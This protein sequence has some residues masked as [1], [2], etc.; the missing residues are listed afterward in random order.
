MHAVDPPEEPPETL[1]GSWGFFVMPKAEFSV[2]E[3]IANSSKFVFPI[4]RANGVKRIAQDGTSIVMG[5][6]N[7]ARFYRFLDDNLD[8]IFDTDPL[9]DLKK[10]WSISYSNILFINFFATGGRDD[11]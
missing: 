2:E 11:R 4:N 1:L 8:M 5:A 7:F 3:P 10:N 9:S 6:S